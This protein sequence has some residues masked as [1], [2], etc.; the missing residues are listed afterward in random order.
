[1]VLAADLP[2]VFIIGG[3]VLFEEAFAKDL[4]T[5]IFLTTVHAEVDG[6]AIFYLPNEA[7]WKVTEVDARQAD[8]KN[9]YAFTFK[10]LEKAPS[11]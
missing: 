1:M 11:D 9:E 7:A 6:D 2:Q 5:K 10:T 4:I 8:D 3:A